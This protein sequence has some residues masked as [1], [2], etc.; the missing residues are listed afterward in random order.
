MAC[1]SSVGELHLSVL[2]K[3][4]NAVAGSS[5][6]AS[7]SKI[8][9]MSGMQTC[10]SILGAVCCFSYA[11]GRAAEVHRSLYLH[12]QPLWLSARRTSSRPIEHEYQARRKRVCSSMQPC[13]ALLPSCLLACS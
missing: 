3:W 12:T 6:V 8:T 5:R 4:Q 11:K 7:S 13:R 2:S 1:M 10:G 9:K